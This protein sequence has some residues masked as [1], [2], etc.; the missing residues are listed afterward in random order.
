MILS[1]GRPKNTSSNIGSQDYEKRPVAVVVGGGFD[2]GM[3]AAMKDACKGLK[4]VWG[5]ADRTKLSEM[6]SLD[7]PELFGAATAVRVQEGLKRHGVGEGVE[8]GEFVY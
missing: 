8:E 4:A 6:P 5:H 3:L 2:D 7:Q 1:G